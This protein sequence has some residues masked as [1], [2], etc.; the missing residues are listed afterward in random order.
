[1]LKVMSQDLPARTAALRTENPGASGGQGDMVKFILL[2]DNPVTCADHAASP[3]ET[4]HAEQGDSVNT[5]LANSPS[6]SAQNIQKTTPAYE[7]TKLPKGQGLRWSPDVTF[8]RKSCSAPALQSVKSPVE[9]SRDG[10]RKNLKERL[11]T[12]IPDHEQKPSAFLLGKGKVRHLVSPVKKGSIPFLTG[13]K[14]IG[15]KCG[16]GHGTSQQNLR[17]FDVFSLINKPLSKE[18]Q[19]H[20]INIVDGPVDRDKDSICP[21]VIPSQCCGESQGSWREC[22]YALIRF[23]GFRSPKESKAAQN[24]A[25]QR[26]CV[27]FTRPTQNRLQRISYGQRVLNKIAL[28]SPR[29]APDEKFW[30]VFPMPW[31]QSFLTVTQGGMSQFGALELN[32][33]SSEI[34]NG[35]HG[36]PH[37]GDQSSRYSRRR[38]GEKQ[39]YCQ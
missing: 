34:S 22:L 30:H 2:T 12:E 14:K 6:F 39:K 27:P 15:G 37:R 31:Q 17:D 9:L 19:G 35:G 16:I 24:V 36:S 21:L 23:Y 38:N 18:Y 33:L 8:A 32:W 28:R 3:G 11:R 1:M 4:S 13:S 25:A 5:S 26:P 10:L 20:T 29:K 7:S